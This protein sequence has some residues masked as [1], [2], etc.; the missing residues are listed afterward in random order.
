MNFR[1]AS[2]ITIILLIL[3]WLCPSQ[4]G[5]CACDSALDTCDEVFSNNQ[6]ADADDHCACQMCASCGQINSLPVMVSAAVHQTS[7]IYVC[8]EQCNRA[9][10]VCPDIFIPPEIS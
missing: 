6:T 2:S 10:L 3:V 1:S 5:F 8:A 9:P 7:G 4:M